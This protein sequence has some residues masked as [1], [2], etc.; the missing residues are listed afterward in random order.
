MRAI[1]TTPRPVPSRVWPAVAGT[2][3]VALG[4]PVFLVADWPLSGWAIAAVLWV[5]GETLAFLLGRLPLDLDHLAASGFVGIA[6]TVRVIGV[7]VVLIA[8]TV[9]DR[10][11]GIAA[12]GLYIAA[13]TLELAVSLAA[14]FS[15]EPR[16]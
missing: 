1:L 6:M 5:A 7:M 9:A 10:P 14:Y 11:V 16:R 2:S 3:V 15:G 4:L 12:A 13:Y 8:V